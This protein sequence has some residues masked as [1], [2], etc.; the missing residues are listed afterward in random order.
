MPTSDYDRI[1]TALRFLDERHAEQPRLDDL[2]ARLDLSPYH[3]QRLFQRWAGVSPKRFLQ[4]ATVE[5]AKE[6]LAGDESVLDAAFEVGLSG[7]GRLH[8]HLVALEAMTPGEIKSGGRGLEVRHGTA[9]SPFGP[10]FLAWT[11]RGLCRLSFLDDPAAGHGELEALR[12]A[13]PGAELAAHPAGARSRAE[14][15][16]AGSGDSPRE[17]PLHVRGTNFQ[18]QVWKALLRVPPGHLVSYGRL[19]EAVDRPQA[20]RAVAGALAAN[21]VLYLI[22]C[23]RVIRSLGA[24]SGYRCGPLRKR[25]LVAREA[26]RAEA[27]S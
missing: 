2:A 17:I 6:R 27:H 14:E 8:D 26:A 23:H 11:P 18:V 12:T 4:F 24:W 5:H 19:A 15:V 25:A 13:L 16:F 3:V 9:D 10:A 7:P 1:E 21:P 22:P 20:A